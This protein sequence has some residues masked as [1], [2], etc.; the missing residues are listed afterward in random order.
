[1]TMSFQSRTR[2]A[3]PR[4][5]VLG[6]LVVLALVSYG[7]FAGGFLFAPYAE[8]AGTSSQGWNGIE[9]T[10]ESKAA[11]ELENERL[12]EELDAQSASVVLAE[13]NAESYRQL[14]QSV[15]GE[16]EEK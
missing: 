2:S 11:L 5:F 7:L 8:L 12:Q 13:I 16:G 6:T 9:R 14:K 15:L 10:F 1:M 3:T 4:I